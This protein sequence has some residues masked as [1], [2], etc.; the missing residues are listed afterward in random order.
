MEAPATSLPATP[1][2]FGEVAAARGAAAE[3]TGGLFQ[4][5]TGNVDLPRQGW[6][7]P[8]QKGDPSATQRPNTAAAEDFGAG[9]R[10]SG[11]SENPLLEQPN[12]ET[13]PEQ[14]LYDEHGDPIDMQ[15]Y[16]QARA[17][18]MN[19]V[20]AKLDDGQFPFDE[21]KTLPVTV[22]V[23]G[24]E[25]QVS[26]EEMRDGYM[27]TANYHRQ[28]QQ[29][30]QLRDQAQHVLNLERARN[31]EWKDPA[32]LRAGMRMLGLEESFMQA[33]F[34]WARE[35]VAYNRLPPRERQ[36]YDAMKVEKQRAEAMDAQLRQQQMLQRQ[37]QG[38]DPATIHVAKQIE[39][40]MPRALKA[41][42]V[43]MYPLAQQ[44]FVEN[45]A[46]IC[47]DGQVDNDRAMEAARSTREFLED[48]ARLN[49]G[50]A[51]PAARHL[52]AERGAHEVMLPVNPSYPLGP[53]RLAGSSRPQMMLGTFGTGQTAANN[54]ATKRRSPSGFNQR[55]GLG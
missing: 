21:L 49:S 28:L 30:H 22:K 17:E 32:Q 52:P 50:G 18:V 55:F 39:Q 2:N 9:A 44:K 45:L 42:G 11:D 53:R 31:H 36:L 38:P 5:Q 10:D 34:Q 8:Q 33:A 25:R 12:Q 54:N 7:Q 6:A 41:A 24:E 46:L 15:A 51:S 27:R 37:Q 20:R 48:L 35:Q 19:K 4:P 23:N 47:Q 13:P 29:A 14:Q 3:S 43:G 16:E 26:L 1:S 40:L